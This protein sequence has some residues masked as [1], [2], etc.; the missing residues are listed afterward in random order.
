MY[1]T[2]LYFNEWMFNLKTGHIGPLFVLFVIALLW[3]GYGIKLELEHEHGRAQASIV[4]MEMFDNF[5]LVISNIISYVRIMALALAH[6]GLV[7]AFQVIGEIGGPVLLAI[8]YVLANIMVIMLEGLVSF[9][10]NLRLHFYEWFTKFY[11]DRGKLFEPAVQYT[12]II[13]E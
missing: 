6:W 1:L 12:K 11:I 4:G 2:G 13:I 5:L 10:H 7:F 3:R 8:L 9:I